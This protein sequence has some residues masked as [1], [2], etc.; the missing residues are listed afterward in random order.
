M[1][2]RS[3]A[4]M[5][6]LG[7][8]SVLRRGVTISVTKDE[9]PSPARPVPFNVQET[10]VLPY[11]EGFYKNLHRAMVEGAANLE[12]DANYLDLPAYHA[13][14]APRPETWADEDKENILVLC[15]FGEQYS[16]FYKERLQEL[17]QAFTGDKNPQRMLDLRSP[18]LVGQA[19]YEQIRWSSRC[20]VDWT[21]WRP[22]V[23]FEL[24]VRLACSEQDPLCIIDQRDQ[25]QDPAN[26]DLSP[27]PLRQRTQ[28]LE[29][30]EPVAYDREQ[31]HGVLSEVL[32]RWIKLEQ[33][34]DRAAP[35]PQAVPMG[36]TFAVAQASFLWRQD[37]M[38]DPPH[39]EER[40]RAERIFG[41]NPEL[42]PER[43]TLFGANHQFDAQLRDAVR[44]K[45]I[46]AWLYL[47]HLNDAAE[48]CPDDVRAELRVVGGLAQDA[49][50][51]S[52][53]PR[54]VR[55]RKEIRAFLRAERS[56]PRT[57]ENGGQDD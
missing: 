31:P 30:F 43:L 9:L 19:L 15:P 52:P 39:V 3:P 21:G 50:R 32:E 5:L 22:N 33:A 11:K 18:R 13:V 26:A 34:K 35:T 8:R 37:G 20:I 10:R 25:N 42:R 27:D 49:L 38:L 56:P 17:I 24:G 53:D 4:V 1:L 23:F 55:L 54:H 51:H 48:E 44:E 29:L 2:F 45:W 6:L 47:R 36:G 57:R 46:A 16:T 40:R 14:R 28:L 41:K 7:I 12:R